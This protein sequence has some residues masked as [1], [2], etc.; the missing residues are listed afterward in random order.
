M[1]NLYHMELLDKTLEKA[2][3]RRN[4][5]RAYLYLLEHGTSTPPQIAR[6]T[7]IARPNL[8][9]SLQTLKDR[10]LISEQRKGSRKTYIAVDP[11][12]LVQT[13][14]HQTEEMR[15]IL[16][17]LRGLYAA[18]TNK[19]VIKYYEGT[20]QVKE[21]FYEMLE[22]KNVYGVAST[23]K[24]YDA[25]G[26]DFFTTYIKKMK[27][28]GIVLH[29]ILTEDSSTTS[30][31]TPI[32]LLKGLYDA[33]ILPKGT[34]NLAVDILVWDDKVALISTEAPIFGTLI[35]NQ[36]IASVLKIM[37]NLSWKQLS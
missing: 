18:Q 15:Q 8:Y 29:D 31:Q 7:K 24:L 11:S 30:A 5:I 19:P 12:V 21:I 36:A 27:D 22:T 9:S 20:E 4:E 3:L 1:I 6:S 35:K 14:E 16:P 25:L 34:E 28:R 2:G 23:K 13:L 26:W 37:F 32:K 10:G 17:D 33:R